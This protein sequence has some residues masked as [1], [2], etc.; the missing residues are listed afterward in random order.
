MSDIALHWIDGEWVGS[1]RV[2]D[3]INPATG[4]VLGRYADA[5]VAEARASV[6]A[7]R[8]AFAAGV[9]ARDRTLR[10]RALSEMAD[11]FDA[12]AEALGQ[13]VT[14]ENGKK[15]GAFEAAFVG[16]TLRH[17]AAQALTG[18]GISAEVEPGQ[19]F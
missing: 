14:S 15:E 4:E 16:S 12:N 1:E 19:W 7:A 6:A 2:S 13:L 18:T 17:T 3:S 5:G 8:A 9:W 10:H 11:R